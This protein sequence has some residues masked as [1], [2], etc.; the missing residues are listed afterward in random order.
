MVRQ[1]SASRPGEAERR[2]IR[3]NKI[4]AIGGQGAE[5]KSLQAGIQDIPAFLQV[6]GERGEI[7]IGLGEAHRDGALQVRRRW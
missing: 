2:E 5:A 1:N 3:G 4:A 6:L 7:R